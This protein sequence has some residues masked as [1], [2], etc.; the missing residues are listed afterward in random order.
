MNN[1][2]YYSE[3]M[4]CRLRGKEI[5]G[6]LH[7]HLQSFLNG[8]W[9]A[10]ETAKDITKFL[11]WDLGNTFH[12][13]HTEL[14]LRINTRIG[15]VVS[16]TVGDMILQRHCYLLTQLADFMGTSRDCI[17]LFVTSQPQQLSKNTPTAPAESPF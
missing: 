8:G 9:Y 4:S 3:E 2:L 6:L 10:I 13:H 11:R 1:L 17:A 15:V 5:L 7:H 12:L 16:A 14:H